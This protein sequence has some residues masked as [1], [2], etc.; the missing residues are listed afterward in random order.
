MSA[1]F[2][3]MIAIADNVYYIRWLL[4]GGKEA[5]LE[6]MILGPFSHQFIEFLS[7]RIINSPN[8]VP[9]RASQILLY[10]QTSRI[11]NLENLKGQKQPLKTGFWDFTNQTRNSIESATATAVTNSQHRIP[12]EIPAKKPP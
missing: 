11:Q 2:Q 7:E 9:K 4:K 10:T 8:A 1:R 6:F 3:G 5:L 12:L